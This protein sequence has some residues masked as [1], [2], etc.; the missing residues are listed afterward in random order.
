MDEGANVI[1]ATSMRA[2]TRRRTAHIEI[3]FAVLI[4]SALSPLNLYF[5][6]QKESHMLSETARL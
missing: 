3:Y 1:N 4:I 5:N 2:P 6:M